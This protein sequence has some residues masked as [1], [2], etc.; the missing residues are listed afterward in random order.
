[1]IEKYPHAFGNR[2]KLEFNC[3]ANKME[4][5]I[6][7]SGK[8]YDGGDVGNE[9]DRLIYEYKVDGKKLKVDFCGVIRHGP[10]P[11]FLNCNS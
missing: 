2:E 9:P 6:L 10:T 4:F 1:M 5:P 11:N 3:G 8:T 7:L